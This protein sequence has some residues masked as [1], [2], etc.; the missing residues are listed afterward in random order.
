MPPAQAAIWTARGEQRQLPAN[1]P[2][3]D[4]HMEF[5]AANQQTYEKFTTTKQDLYEGMMALVRDTH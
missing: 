4:P 1:I 5:T 2:W 3:C